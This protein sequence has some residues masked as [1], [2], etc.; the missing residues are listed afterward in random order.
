MVIG[1]DCASPALVFDRFRACLPRVSRLMEEGTWGPMR[2]TL[3][4]VT[5]PAWACMLSGRDPGQLGLYGFRDRRPGSYELDLVDSGRLRRPLVWD[6]LGAA[7]KRVAVLFV[8][9]SYPPFEVPGSLVSCFLTPG[10]DS[11]HTY[12]ASLQGELEQRFGAYLPDVEGFRLRDRAALPGELERMAEQHFGIAEYIWQTRQPDCL[13][14]VEMGPDRLHHAFWRHLY[15]EE[16][17]EAEDRYYER[18][19][20]RYYQLIDERVGRLADLA[21]E[22]TALLLVSDHG[23]RSLQGGICIN[24]LLIE[25]GYLALQQYPDRV[26]PFSRLRVDWS[27]TRAWGE[28]G[29]HGRVFLNLVGRE[30]L[31]VVEPEER[32]SECKR[33]AE[34]IESVAG[35]DGRKLDNRV[36]GPEQCYLETRGFPPDLYAFFHDLAFRSIGSVGHG[37]IHTPVNDRGPDGCNHHWDGI[38]VLSGAAAPRRG[39]SAGFA[40][41]DVASTILGLMGVPAPD[42]LLGV[43]RSR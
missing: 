14:M 10:A 35:P 18:V 16:A 36:L 40:I 29:Y 21:G 15:P 41:Y 12:P 42:D 9:P 6:I 28:G 23:A 24:E 1:L 33:L 11:P 7:G 31:G 34:L 27:R 39:K 13:I 25:H 32:G 22:E 19:C 17:N 2:S 26:T 8:P 3:P 4:P 5:V 38:F 30:P 20:R 43:D 37:T